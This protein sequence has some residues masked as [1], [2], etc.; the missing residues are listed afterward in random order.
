MDGEAFRDGMHRP[1]MKTVHTGFVVPNGSE[2]G[3]FYI[4]PDSL[5]LLE[6]RAG[7]VY[8]VEDYDGYFIWMGTM[9]DPP[10]V[11]CIIQR[12]GMAFMWPEADK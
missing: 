6:A 3:C 8:T 12:N 11:Q 10:Y 1:S 9:D 5:H 2:D 7:D 4:H